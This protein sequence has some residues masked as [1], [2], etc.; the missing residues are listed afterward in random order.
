MKIF[1]IGATGLTGSYLLPRLVGEGHEV[2]ALT[3]SA[4]KTA[5]IEA[6]GA[7]VIIGDIRLPS[8]FIPH[9]YGTP[10]IIIL[11]AMPAVTPGERITRKR[12]KALKEETN[13]FFRNSMEMALK[14]D[15]P[16]ILPGGTSFRTRDGEVADETWSIRRKGILEIG[17]DTDLMVADAISKGNPKIIQLL[18]GKIY[19]NG[20]LFRKMFDMMR[21]GRMKI[22]G[23]GRNCIPN[24]HASD[25]A[26]AIL[27]AIEKLPVGHRFIIADDTPVT[28]AEFT[29]LMARLMNK[30]KPGRIPGF[31]VRLVIGK[32]LYV[33][34]SMDCKVSNEKAKKMLGWKP[35]YASYIEGLENVIGEMMT[36]EPYFSQKKN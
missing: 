20:G 34:I 18:Y 32:D 35:V 2:W 36:R 23:K 17:S 24:I 27:C 14:F 12:K 22:I 16:V 9:L 5:K 13:D 1:V 30:N 10:D 31:I 19:G 28:Q 29:A 8:Q 33:V 3:R 15:V 7:K 11:L 21:S 6:L 4:G 25:A 26:S